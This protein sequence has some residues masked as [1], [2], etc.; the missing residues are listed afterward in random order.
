MCEAAEESLHARPPLQLAGGPG[1]EEEEE[2]GSVDVTG[3]DLS[4]VFVNANRYAWHL[5]LHGIRA[6]G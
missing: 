2:V 5:L 1:G 4:T 6:I 3:T